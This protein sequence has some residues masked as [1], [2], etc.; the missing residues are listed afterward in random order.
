M[1]RTDRCFWLA[2]SV[3]FTLL[4]AGCSS[5]LTKPE[6]APR[7]QTTAPVTRP[8]EPPSAQASAEPPSR[9]RGAYYLDDGPGDKQPT[10]LDS[11]PDAVP[12]S[13]ALHPFANQPYMAFGARYFPATARAKY[14]ARGIASWYGRRFHG[15]P[16]ASG[17]LYDMY[18]MTGAHPTLP[19][20]S[21][22]RVTNL[23]NKKS[24]VVRINDRGPF[25][26]DRL[27][28]L[29]YTAALKL[30]FLSQGSAEVEV[31]T[32][33]ARDES[34]CVRRPPRSRRLR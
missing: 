22:V 9:R 32:L 25:R 14:K 3:Q 6:P 30:G 29:S 21:Y 16:T 18:E 23:K 15:K 20:P 26:R 17:E 8:P 33:L 13:E 2:L 27:I 19:I 10:H 5:A 11:V 7:Q 24:V 12:R 28:D 31:E 1:H 4:L 34:P